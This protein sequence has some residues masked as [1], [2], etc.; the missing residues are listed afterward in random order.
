MAVTSRQD[1]LQKAIHDHSESAT[2]QMA[3]LAEDQQKMQGGLDALTATT[4][5]TAQDVTGVTTRQDALQTALQ[6]YSGST[7]AQTAKLA[8]NQQRIQTGIDA[9][10][11][12]TGQT[13]QDVAKVAELQ[14]ALQKAVQ[15]Y[16][17]SST[18]QTAK[19][20]EDQRKMQSGIDALA[21]TASQTA[22]DVTDVAA[23]QDA[24]QKAI[25][26]YSESAARQ[27]AFLTE[28]QQKM[29][30]GLDTVTA[31]SGQ[32]AHDVAALGDAQ[33]KSEQNAQT[34]RTEVIGRLETIAQDQQG[35]VQRFDAAQARIQTMA[36]GIAALDQQLGKLQGALQ[37]GIQD[38]TTALGTGG[39]QRQQFEAKVAQD[40]QAVMEAI[41]QL[42]QAQAQLQEQ[43][44]QVQKSTQNQAE[45]LKATLEQIKQ[46]PA[47]VKVSDTANKAEPVT[48]QTG[49]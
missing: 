45:T 49:Q 17:E 4:N 8:E 2:G 7:T 30:S 25:A 42:R 32:T 13:V 22:K 28:S 20:A 36:E 21:A 23:Q 19:L 27:L 16:S 43:M 37:T 5:Q 14:D 47:E 10:T 12:T 34:G 6:D 24:L 39:Q 40:I 44:G 38:A 15:N 29:Q 48:V 26:D 11:A 35:W 31:S 18:A 1:T 46:P 3:K 9:L 33:A 41:S